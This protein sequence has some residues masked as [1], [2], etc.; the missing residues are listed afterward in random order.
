MTLAISF[1]K[2]LN[3]QNLMYL[4]WI[5]YFLLIVMMNC[6]SD[7]NR[8]S[9]QLPNVIVIFTDDQGYQDLGCYGSPDIKT[10]HIDQMAEEGIRFTNFYVSQGVCSASRASLLTGC[11]ADR[12]GIS[13]AYMP[14]VGKGLHPD[15]ETIA[16]ILK[17]KGYATACYGKWHLGSEEIFLPTNQGFDEYFGI[18]YSNDMWPLHPWQGSVFNFPALPLIEGTEVID[19]LEDQSL[20]TKW[21]TDRAVDFIHRN[22]GK[23]FFLY[24]PHSMPHVPLYRSNEFVDTSKAGIYGDVIEEIDWSTGEILKALKDNKIDDNTLVIFTSDNGP[25]LSYGTH[26]GRALPLREGKGTALEGGVRV[27]C[28]MRWPGFIPK[29]I[30]EERPAMTIDL[31]PTIVNITNADLPTKEI[32]GTDMTYLLKGEKNKDLHHKAYFFY[33]KKNELHAILSGDGRWKLYLPHLYRSI[34]GRIGT[35][36]GIPIPY[37]QNQMGKELYDLEND[38]EET[39]NVADLHP[40]VVQSLLIHAEKARVE[41]GDQLTGRNGQKVRAEGK[42]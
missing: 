31:L 39:Q 35:S 12:L 10:P 3:I 2:K 29:G 22:S 33:Y 1:S 26:S 16:E 42:I 40:E 34:N 23:P 18:P 17:Q 7:V 5:G 4:K 32:D 11:Y 6:S 8:E 24:V 37:D 15:E 41:L 19:T 28:V 38:I 20:I 13:G 9:N 36:D 14:Y 21:Y 25:W 30:V 27:P